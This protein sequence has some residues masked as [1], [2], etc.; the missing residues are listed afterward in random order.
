MKKYWFIVVIAIVFFISSSVGIIV[1]GCLNVDEDF[2]KVSLY[3]ILCILLDLIVGILV[4]LMILFLT[5]FGE[6][7]KNKKE[8]II[9]YLYK[10]EEKIEELE[11]LIKV[12]NL[13]TFWNC[14]LITKSSVEATIRSIKESKL[15]S[16]S[17]KVFLRPIEENAREYFVYLQNNFYANATLTIEIK[18]EERN[19]REMLKT[20]ITKMVFFVS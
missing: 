9:R 20:K 12:N 19:K 15:L 17:D 3:E 8:V 6:H 11:G 1:F 16:K 5:F 2:Y 13:K 4:A 10:I 7:Q 18:T 14:A